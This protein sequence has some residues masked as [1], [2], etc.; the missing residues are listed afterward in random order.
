MASTV[1]VQMILLNLNLELHLYES[2]SEREREKKRER[3][4]R[5]KVDLLV[6]PV[7]GRRVCARAVAGTAVSVV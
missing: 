5:R 1:I 6:V 3:R 2:D 4:E 7:S